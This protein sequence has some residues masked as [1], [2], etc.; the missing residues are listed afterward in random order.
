MENFCLLTEE[1]RLRG[2]EFKIAKESF[3]TTTRQ[4]FLTN[5]VFENWN[6]L[7]SLIVS[8]ENVSQFKKR[9]GQHKEN[10]D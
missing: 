8:V 6:T 10:H 9:Y 3:K 1:R 7:P 4:H 5:H 2:H